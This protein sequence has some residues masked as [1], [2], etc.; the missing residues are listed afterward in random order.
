MSR[1]FEAEDSVVSHQRRAVKTA[2][3]GV[4]SHELVSAL[5][6]TFYK[7]GSARTGVALSVS[8]TVGGVLGEI[9]S[10][11]VIDKLMERARK[12]TG[13]VRPEARLHGMWPAI[14]LLPAGLLMFGFCIENHELK[15]SYIGV[16]VG[17]AL[18]CKSLLCCPESF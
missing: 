17:M 13:R 1:A 9:V 14:F 3:G 7:W 10:G 16:T 8:T 2:G 4:A 12:R 6:R 15:H 5:F 18:T 11:P